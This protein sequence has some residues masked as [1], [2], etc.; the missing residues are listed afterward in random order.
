[1][2]NCALAVSDSGGVQEESSVVK[3]P[4]VVVRRSTERP[5]VVGTFAELVTAGPR[6]GEVAGAWL[7]DLPAVHARL[8]ALD[9]PYG[10]GH[11]SQRTVAALERMLTQRG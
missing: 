4:V 9:T 2:A 5:E 1:M 6:I 10:D 7:D 3:R 8:A 11:A